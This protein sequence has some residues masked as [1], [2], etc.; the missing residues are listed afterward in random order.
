MLDENASEVTL[1]CC[2]ILEEGDGK[3]LFCDTKK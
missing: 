1:D 2:V 3:E